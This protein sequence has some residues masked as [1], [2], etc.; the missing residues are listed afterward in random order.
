MVRLIGGCLLVLWHRECRSPNWAIM[1]NKK[2]S[3]FTLVELMIVVAIIGILAA[4]AIPAFTRYIKK[5]RTVEAFGFLNKEWAGS[6]TYYMTDFSTSGAGIAPRQF[7]MPSGTWEATSDCAW[8]TGAH[9]PGNASV[10]SS[11]QV[12]LALKFSL[13]DPHSY[14]P[15]YSGAGTGTS[16]QFT[17]YVR[18]DMD[19]DGTLAEFSRFGNVGGNGD[20]AGAVQPYIVNEY[21]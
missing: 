19:C 10:W 17:A 8:L 1:R 6:V 15:G 16:A 18:G 4:I 13:P 9:C 2:S 12:W 3:G 5:S 11:D 20:V 14:M 7:P 21:E